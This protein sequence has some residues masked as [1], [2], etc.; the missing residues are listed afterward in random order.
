M[1]YVRYRIP[2][3][4]LN[5]NCDCWLSLL[6]ISALILKYICITDC[7]V[8]KRIGEN[9]FIEKMNEVLSSGHATMPE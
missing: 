7:L 4:V 8:F 5:L 2:N 6:L 1:T 3:T 9:I